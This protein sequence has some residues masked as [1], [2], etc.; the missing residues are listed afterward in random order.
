MY[1]MVEYR[2]Q[3]V[4]YFVCIF[5]VFNGGTP[6]YRQLFV[7]VRSSVCLFVHPEFGTICPDVLPFCPKLHIW[8]NKD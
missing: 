4:T 7:S 1:A 2:Y 5:L 8:V 6:F 3:F